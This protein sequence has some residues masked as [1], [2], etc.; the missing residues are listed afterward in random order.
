MTCNSTG[1][2]G[3]CICIYI[4][5]YVCTYLHTD[6]QRVLLSDSVTLDSVSIVD[7]EWGEATSYTLLLSSASKGQL[8]VFSSSAIMPKHRCISSPYP[9]SMP[10]LHKRSPTQA[11]GEA[12]KLGG[13]IIEFRF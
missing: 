10:K 7:E 2:T 8:D 4:Y 12:V 11:A 6:T 13:S 5:V 3:I 9:Q 1:H